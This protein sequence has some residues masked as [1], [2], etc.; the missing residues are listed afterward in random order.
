M[1]QCR[2]HRGDQFRSLTT[3]YKHSVHDF[4]TISSQSQITNYLFL[5]Y[6]AYMQTATVVTV[7]TGKKTS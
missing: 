4:A 6:T 3:P 1:T 2:V 5:T 7:I